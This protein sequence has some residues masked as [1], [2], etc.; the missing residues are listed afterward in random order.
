M[1]QIKLGKSG[2]DVYDIDGEKILK[3]VCRDKLRENQGEYVYEKKSINFAFPAF[4][5]RTFQKTYPS[6][7]S[8]AG[9]LIPSSRSSR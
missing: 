5:F 3:H 6:A 8:D 4:C 2:A 9:V 7:S 1:T